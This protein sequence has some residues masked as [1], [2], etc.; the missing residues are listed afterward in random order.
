MDQASKV[1]FITVGGNRLRVDSEGSSFDPGG[2]TREPVN[3]ANSHDFT[4]KP[5]NA[6]MSGDI[7]HVAGQSL[8]YFNNIENEDVTVELDTGGQWVMPA[9]CSNGEAKLEDGRV[10]NFMLYSAPAEEDV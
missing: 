5:R 4:K 7:I 10:K 9:A 6:S 8:L 1:M 3:G 2:F